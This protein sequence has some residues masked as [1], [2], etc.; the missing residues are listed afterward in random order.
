MQLCKLK[1]EYAKQY[2]SKEEL[3]LLY[4]HYYDLYTRLE[5]VI[6]QVKNEG[7]RSKVE[8]QEMN[9]QKKKSKKIVEKLQQLANYD[10]LTHVYNRRYLNIKQA[11]LFNSSHPLRIGFVIFDVDFFKEYNDYYGHALGDQVLQQVAACIQKHAHKNMVI[12]RYGGDEFICLSWDSSDVDLG[13]FIEQI[14]ETLNSMAIEHSQSNCAKVVTLSI[15]YGTRIFENRSEL[16]SLFED[17]DEALYQAKKKG[18]NSV[19]AIAV[20]E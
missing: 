4:H 14:K 18:R 3:A 17:V 10:A 12:C 5:L 6:N 19:V 15:G 2:E 9:N 11:E 8:L 13:K 1:I 16:F 20:Q 7:L